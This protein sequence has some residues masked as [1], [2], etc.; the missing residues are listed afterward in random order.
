VVARGAAVA[1]VLGRPRIWDIS[2]GTALLDAIGGELRYRSGAAVD[3]AALLAG[4]RAADH[5]VAAAP[6]MMDEI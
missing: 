3:L 2:A 1:A 4:E 6:G 5:L